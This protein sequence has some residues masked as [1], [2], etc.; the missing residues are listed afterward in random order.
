MKYDKVIR[1]GI[2][3]CGNI[4]VEQTLN[5]LFDQ[6]NNQLDKSR[7]GF[8]RPANASD[9]VIHTFRYLDNLEPGNKCHISGLDKLSIGVVIPV[10]DFRSALASQMRKRG[11][12]PTKITI[13][14][15]Y[16]DL[17]VKM[18]MEMHRYTTDF[19][20][21]ED[22]LLLDY[23]EYFNNSDYLLDELGRFLDIDIT[24]SQRSEIKQRFSLEANSK[25]AKQMSSWGQMDTSSGIHGRHIGTGHP[26]S[27]KIFFPPE[28]HGFVTELMMSELVA[29]G[30]ES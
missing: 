21:P 23:R 10:R 3:G 17:F 30:L 20:K 24:D 19:N 18:Y 13:A 28:L 1:A 11:I 29:Y 9:I 27:W 12:S 25:I 6:A 7:S 22:V 15:M 2:N 4:V 5:Y 26:E 8:H 14:Q 16:K